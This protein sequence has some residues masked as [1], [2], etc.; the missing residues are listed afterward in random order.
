M[1]KGVERRNNVTFLFWTVGTLVCRKGD[2]ETGIIV[3]V[4]NIFRAADGSRY[5][6]R[7]DFFNDESRVYTLRGAHRYLEY[8][9]NSS[10]CRVIP[11]FVY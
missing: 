6:I 8:V 7:V 4:H 10:L 5:G 3:S 2:G 9:G 11:L 1:R